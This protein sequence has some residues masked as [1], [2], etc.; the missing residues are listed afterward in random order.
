MGLFKSLILCFPDMGIRFFSYVGTELLTKSASLCLCI[1]FVLCFVSSKWDVIQ[2]GD[3][4]FF[5]SSVHVL[6]NEFSS[7]VLCVSL[8]LTC[9]FNWI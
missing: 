7:L 4:L 5:V 6:L 9:S 2:L 1:Y 8:D 3:W